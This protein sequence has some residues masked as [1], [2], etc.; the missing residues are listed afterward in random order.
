MFKRLTQAYRRRELKQLFDHPKCGAPFFCDAEGTRV[1][2][3][4]VND[5]LCGVNSLTLKVLPLEHMYLPDSHKNQDLPRDLKY[6][7]KRTKR[8]VDAVKYMSAFGYNAYALMPVIDIDGIRWGVNAGSC[9]IEGFF[10]LYS[11]TGLELT[12][13]LAMFEWMPNVIPFHHYTTVMVHRD[14]GMPFNDSTHNHVIELRLVNDKTGAYHTTQ[15]LTNCPGIGEYRTYSVVFNVA[16]LDN[17]SVPVI[18]LTEFFN[19]MWHGIKHPNDAYTIDIAKIKLLVGNYV[20]PMTI[21]ELYKDNP[22]WRVIM[23]EKPNEH[24]MIGKVR[25]LNTQLIPTAFP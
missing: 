15:D 14:N 13:P 23:S 12:L 24:G 20:Q 5:M 7:A 16:K 3:I 4:K 1:V 18:N 21:D 19:A 8:L 11:T 2:M 25:Y 17:S 9:D 22:D 6:M 10:K